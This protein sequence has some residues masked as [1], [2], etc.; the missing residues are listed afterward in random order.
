LAEMSSAKISARRKA[1]VLLTLARSGIGLV[2]R[3]EPTP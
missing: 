2:T 3:A 1:R